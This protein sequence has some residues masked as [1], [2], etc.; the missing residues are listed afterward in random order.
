[1][2]PSF[3]LNLGM[4]EGVQGAGRGWDEYTRGSAAPLLLPH[5]L[6]GS[7]SHCHVRMEKKEPDS[8]AA[9]LMHVGRMEAG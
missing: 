2:A 5:L 4:D 8:R 9:R 6:A 7:I 1:M 3:R